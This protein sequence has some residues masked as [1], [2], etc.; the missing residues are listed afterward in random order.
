M[1]ICF[2][3]QVTWSLKTKRF[4]NI[5]LLFCWC[6]KHKEI[7]D[8]NNFYT[9]LPNEVVKITY[10]NLNPWPTLQT[11]HRR[12][13]REDVIRACL[14]WWIN[15]GSVT[16]RHDYKVPNRAASVWIGNGACVIHELHCHG[17]RSCGPRNE[18]SCCLLVIISWYECG[19]V[20]HCMEVWFQLLYV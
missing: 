7:C 18:V 6:W 2:T 16:W 5:F 4:Q 11:K 14:D 20:F 19:H 10:K 13:T 17:K 3:A 9:T 12:R 15:E 8:W 1:I